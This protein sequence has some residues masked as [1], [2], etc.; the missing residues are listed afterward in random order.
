VVDFLQSDGIYFNYSINL[1]RR[2]YIK[3]KNKIFKLFKN[4]FFYPEYPRAANKIN[5][6]G[7]YVKFVN[8]EFGCN[9][10]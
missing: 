3:Y 1:E 8:R 2:K 6:K 9:P 5:L 4:V 7:L 10:L